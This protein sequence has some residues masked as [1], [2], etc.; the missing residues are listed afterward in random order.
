MQIS[1]LGEFRLIDRIASALPPLHAHTLRGIGDDCA[2]LRPE[3]DEVLLS[4]TDLLMEGI[5]FD[6]VYSPLRHLG[7]K[8]AMVN[9][10]DLYAMN[11]TPR[12]L[13]AAVALS[14]RFAVED[15][16]EL[17]AG[18]RLA[19]QQHEVDL[20]GGDTSASL[21]GLAL[22]FTALGTARP[23]DICGR[24]GAADTDLICVSGNLGAAYLGLCLLEREKGIHFDLVYSPL[25]HLG[26]KAAVVN[27]S[28]LYAMNAT[29]R[30]LLAG[31]ALSKRFAVE[32]VDELYAGIRL[33]CQ[34]HEVDLAGGDTSASLTGLTL[35]LTALGT[36][37][38]DDICGRDGAQ[39]TDLI[40][41]SGNLGA[42]YLGLCLLEREKGIYLSQLRA[43]K[44]EAA[45]RALNFAPDFSGREYLLERFLKPEARRDIILALR[46][47]GIRPTAMIDVSDGLSSELLHICQR[48]GV[49]CRIYEDRLP[50]DYQ[51]AVAA[52]ELNLNVSTCA[53]NG[54]EDYELLFTV[55]L[56]AHEQVEALDDVK[57]IG[58][59]T[60]SE[61]GAQLVTRDGNEFALR[62]QGWDGVS[63]ERAPESADDRGEA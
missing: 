19:C 60:R 57:I 46:A 58:H 2:V 49:G 18:I 53:L 28:D 50:I 43:A 40:C 54:G 33:A 56:S 11:A 52:E 17:Y 30:Q 14:K 35:S 16:D 62:A 20:A 12:Q 32:D 59:I 47:A 34:Q 38:P 39:D 31:V 26:Y 21:T 24:D 36:A 29:P 25:R 4:T 41:V 5:H 6:L 13:L 63:D 1:E 10:S 44:S 42:A 48:S 9:L 7:Y 37:Q 51:T 3:S 55:P 61:L 8:A 15:V 27:L 45:R 23:A 22:S